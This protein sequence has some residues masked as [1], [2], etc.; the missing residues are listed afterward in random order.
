MDP[1]ARHALLNASAAA[2]ANPA[3]GAGLSLITPVSG[4]G[5]NGPVELN[6][7]LR[8]TRE[9]MTFLNSAT[10]G[11]FATYGTRPARP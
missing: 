7:V 5:W 8:F 4:S 10:P 3:A 9:R 2:A 11:W 6:D 1:N